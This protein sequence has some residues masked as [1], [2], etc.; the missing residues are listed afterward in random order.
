[1]TLDFGLIV[2]NL[3]EI[4]AAFWMTIWIWIVSNIL[5]V[6]FGFAVATLR[7]Y[8]PGWLGLLLRLFVEVIRGTPF[9]VQLFLLYF[10]GPFIGLS[11]DPIPAGLLGMTVYATAYYSEIFRAGYNAV[12]VGHVEAAECVG[13]TRGQIIRRILVPEMTMLVLPQCV[14]MAILMMKETAILSIITVPELTLVVGAIGSQQY[15]FVEAMFLLALFYW[16]LVE[17]SGFLG[18]I[19]EARL[20]KFRFAHS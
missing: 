20:S 3:P 4:L 17:V 5:A 9:L 6:A 19:A 1:M 2:Q 16:F 7:R 15:A 13:L 10:G 18:R 8:G 11:L 14:N 12:P